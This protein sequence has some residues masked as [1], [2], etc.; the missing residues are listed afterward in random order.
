MSSFEIYKAIP[1]SLYNRIV[2][3]GT[4]VESISTTFIPQEKVD[5]LEF[6]TMKQRPAARKI[7]NL[8][9]L[10][11][12]EWTPTFEIKHNNK[13]YPNT[14]MVDILNFLTK[15]VATHKLNTKGLNIVLNALKQQN[16]ADV[17]LEKRPRNPKHKN[18]RWMSAKE[19]GILK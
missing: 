9:K 8:L 7:L 13:V 15:S 5:I 3:E 2:G 6:L 19:S 12:I 14:N 4:H 11:E 16:F 1:V 18:C 10:E 17:N